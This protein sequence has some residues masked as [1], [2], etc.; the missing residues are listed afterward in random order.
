[1]KSAYQGN[2][3][4]CAFARALNL[5]ISTKVCYEIG[6]AI[7]GKSVSKVL[8]FLDRVLEQKEAVPFKRFN[9]DVGHK[10]G[11]IGPGRYPI[12][13]VGYVKKVV[14]SAVANAKDKG[15]SEDALVLVHFTANTGAGQWRHGRQRRRQ[16]KATHLEVVVL[17]SPL[18]KKSPSKAKVAKPL[19]ESS[20]PKQKVDVQKTKTSAATNPPKESTKDSSKVTA[21]K[22]V[23]SNEKVTPSS[24][25]KE[26]SQ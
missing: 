22:P 7:R 11:N 9:A 17:E 14:L 8:A 21:D 18:E 4:K 16:M 24:K 15:L 2:M 6:N 19:T 23:D 10:P 20:T 3:E 12:K 26:V 13:S 25:S 1:M 5:P